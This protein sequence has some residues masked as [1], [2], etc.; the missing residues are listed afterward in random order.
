MRQPAGALVSSTLD[1]ALVSLRQEG[2]IFKRKR[3]D[4]EGAFGRD[5]TAKLVDHLGPDGAS[6]LAEETVDEA[7]DRWRKR[8]DGDV[9]SEEE[10]SRI[11]REAE[12]KGVDTIEGLAALLVL[13]MA[14]KIT[15]EVA[16]SAITKAGLPHELEPELAE[17]LRD[18][19]D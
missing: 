2:V 10:T 6:E 3:F 14:E 4:L 17:R 11:H 12:G 8:E 19:L 9:L 16:F 7:R 18:S 13:A 5:L 1:R 15:G